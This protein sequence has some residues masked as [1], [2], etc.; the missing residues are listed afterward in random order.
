M[1]PDRV[2]LSPPPQLIPYIHIHIHI[3]HP[4]PTS[5]SLHPR[6]ANRPAA[7]GTSLEQYDRVSPLS[8]ERHSYRKLRSIVLLY[9]STYVQAGLFIYVHLCKQ[10]CLYIYMR[11]SRP[12]CKC[13]GVQ[14]GCF[15]YICTSMQEGL[16]MY[17]HVCKQDCRRRER[18]PPGM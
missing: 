4:H 7:Q 13:T 16:F 3:P 18:G 8:V 6:E 10:A 17:V 15:V 5:T 14:A 11:A 9:Q 2:S 1:Q 12:V